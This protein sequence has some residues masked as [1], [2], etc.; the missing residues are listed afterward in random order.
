MNCKRK[1]IYLNYQ[2]SQ[3]NNQID[4]NSSYR[5]D[6]FK[7]NNVQNSRP[8]RKWKIQY[9]SREKPKRAGHGTKKT[10]KS[11]IHF[12]FLKSNKKFTEQATA[13]CN[14]L[15][16]QTF[17][18]H[19]LYLIIATKG[20]RKVRKFSELNSLTAVRVKTTIGRILRE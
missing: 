13:Y 8:G 3:K 6:F 5:R 14:L 1:T 11:K 20:Q 18:K 10:A 17:R 9:F 12:N 2:G 15:S 16:D 19:T 4:T 7:K